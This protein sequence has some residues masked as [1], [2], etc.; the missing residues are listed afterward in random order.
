[1]HNL[2]VPVTSQISEVFLGADQ[3]AIIGLLSKMGTY[4]HIRGIVFTNLSKYDVSVGV[5]SGSSV[6]NCSKF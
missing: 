3:E 1:M 5:T 6:S 2:C 4:C